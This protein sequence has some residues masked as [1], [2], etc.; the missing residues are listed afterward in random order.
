M[1]QGFDIF[2]RASTE[3]FSAALL[4]L[5]IETDPDAKAAI[6]SLLEQRTA[7]TLGQLQGAQRERR[8]E[9]GRGRAYQRADICLRFSGGVVLIE[10]KTRNSWDPTEVAE[11]LEAQASSSGPITWGE[12]PAA[13]L[14]LAPSVLAAQVEALT[15]RPVIRWPD[16]MERL[17][18]LDGS[19]VS[20]ALQHWN[21]RVERPIGLQQPFSAEALVAAIQPVACL[22]AFLEDCARSIGETPQR[23]KLD[24]TG[25]DGG[26]YEY[27]GWRWH[28]LSVPLTGGHRY[29]RIGIYHYIDT[30]D[31]SE[32]DL[33]GPWLEL[34]RSA[35][36]PSG[37]SM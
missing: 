18:H 15:E 4:C 27:G 20:L 36:L 25:Q 14:L 16:L 33:D 26:T 6:V 29:R 23:K 3:N 31:G 8:L 19:L 9:E 28:G 10:V 12:A 17:R 21:K 24:M 22:R 37:V 30:P 35:S 7:L 13:T 32:A 2:D 5:V 34:Y 11:Q 1:P